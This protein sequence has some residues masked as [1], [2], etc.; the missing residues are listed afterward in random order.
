MSYR[1]VLTPIDNFQYLL[2]LPIF[3]TRL[4]RQNIKKT[5]RFVKKF[6]QSFEKV[7]KTVSKPKYI[8]QSSIL[9]SKASHETTF[10]PLT[11]L[12]K[13]AFKVKMLTNLDQ[14]QVTLLGATIFPKKFPRPI[15]SIPKGKISPNL[16]TLVL[17]S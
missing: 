7:A 16:V 2:R 3:M 14:T 10:E 6:A 17:I 13:H 8:H 1:Q 15:R 9:A 11:Y 12:Q 5:K 4:N